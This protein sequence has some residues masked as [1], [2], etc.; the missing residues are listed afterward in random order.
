MY[1]CIMVKYVIRPVRDAFI[2]VIQYYGKI[3]YPSSFGLMIYCSIMIKY[4]T[5]PVRDVVI[6]QFILTLNSRAVKDVVILQ[7]YI[8]I[9]HPSGQG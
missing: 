9:R 4:S 6:F 3:R 7:N 5:R 8:E 1:R 2:H